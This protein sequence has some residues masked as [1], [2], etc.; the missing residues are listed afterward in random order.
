VAAKPDTERQY[1]LDRK[2]EWLMRGDGW[3]SFGTLLLFARRSRSF[4]G[5][6][7]PTE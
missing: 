5:L 4:A 3:I 6:D 7:E 1:I 2:K